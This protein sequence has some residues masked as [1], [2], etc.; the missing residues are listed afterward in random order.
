MSL[1]RDRRYIRNNNVPNT[2]PCGADHRMS[3]NLENHS[4]QCIVRQ[5]FKPQMCYKQGLF[6][7]A[8]EHCYLQPMV[9]EA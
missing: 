4:K 5:L 6:T 1:P 7:H 9:N 2:D 3:C 8:D